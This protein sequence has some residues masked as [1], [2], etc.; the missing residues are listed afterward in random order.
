MRGC[1]TATFLSAAGLGLALCAARNRCRRDRQP[2]VPFAVRRVRASDREQ[3]VGALS[4]GI[5]GGNDYLPQR[6][7]AWLASPEKVM[8]CVEHSETGRVVAFEAIGK[9]SHRATCLI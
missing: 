8:F 2:A 3:I 9:W 4:D 7:D 1:V 6:F 5:Y